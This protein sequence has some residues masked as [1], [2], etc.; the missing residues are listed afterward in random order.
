[1]DKT[2]TTDTLREA[3]Q[4][5]KELQRHDNQVAAMR[6]YC[7][8][9]NLQ[10]LAESTVDVILTQAWRKR[11]VV[12]IREI[13]AFEHFIEFI[14]TESPRGLGEDPKRV[15]GLIR[16]YPEAVRL[17]RELLT[18]PKHKH[19]DRDNYNIIISPKP[20]Q[21]TGLPYTLDFLKRRAPAEIYQQVVDG[22]LSPNAAAIQ[23]GR[24]KWI[25]IPA[26]VQGAARILK[27]HFS[28]EELNTIIELLQKEE[29]DEDTRKR[30][31]KSTD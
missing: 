24:T 16:E 3:A 25:S 11:W 1:M 23:I 10:K 5:F 26:N 9:M 12:E 2:K 30:R 29:S 18:A 4:E 7:H 22:K 8:S 6:R 15:L 28:R 20:E 14:R 19:H 21:G 31:A 27:R 13:V 17:V